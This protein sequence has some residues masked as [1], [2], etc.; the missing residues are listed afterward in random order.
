[1]LTIKQQKEWDEILKEEDW[2]KKFNKLLKYSKNMSS[3]IDTRVNPKTGKEQ[4]CFAID[5]FYGSHQYGYGF[6]KDGSDADFKDFS[7]GYQDRCD[8][9]PWEVV[10]NYNK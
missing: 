6:P 7:K 9:Y 10:K 5:D 2:G 8:F 4:K 3:Y 1:M